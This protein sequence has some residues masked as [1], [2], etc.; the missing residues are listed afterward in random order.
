MRIKNKIFWLFVGVLVLAFSSSPEVRSQ[1]GGPYEITQSVIASGG[2]TSSGGAFGL[3]GTAGQSLAG[4]SLSAQPFS[5]YSGFFAP[6]PIVPTAASVTI[7]GK[8]MRPN[9]KGISRAQVTLTD[10]LGNARTA[11]T[12]RSG[13]YRFD[14]VEVGAAYILLAEAKNYRFSPKTVTPLD[15]VSDLDFTAD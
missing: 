14:D 10:M 5:I 3:D 9:G 6:D 15:E 11:N 7:S 1:S 8:V 12:D 2:G 13:N 4:G